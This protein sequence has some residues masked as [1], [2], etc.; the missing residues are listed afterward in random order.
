MQIAGSSLT[1]LVEELHHRR[2][3]DGMI[4][5]ERVNRVIER[6][7]SHISHHVVV[8]IVVELPTVEVSVVCRRKPRR[9]DE[10]DVAA[11]PYSVRLRVVDPV[12]LACGAVSDKP[13]FPSTALQLLGESLFVH[14][15]PAPDNPEVPEESIL[16]VERLVGRPV[17]ES[18]VRRPIA[19]VHR[20]M[21]Q[22]PPK[23]LR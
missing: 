18:R 20:G 5:R 10:D 16:A 2:F 21:Q 12:R 8:V 9:L 1:D 6:V 3:P 14:E 13:P 11:F 7:V 19:Q 15:R 17:V 22:L 4:G 23:E